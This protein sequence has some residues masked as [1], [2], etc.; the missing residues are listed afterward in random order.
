MSLRHAYWAQF[1]NQTVESFPSRLEDLLMTEDLPKTLSVTYKELFKGSPQ[2][3]LKCREW[4]VAEVPGL[5]GEEWDDM[6]DRPF[7]YL[8]AARDRLIQFKFLH[9]VYYTPARLASIYPSVP[10]ECW[11]CTFAPA[12]AHHVFM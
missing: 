10:A 5:Q 11:R 2:A 3:L 8:V 9:R 6:W 1:D 12:D 4:W 7:K